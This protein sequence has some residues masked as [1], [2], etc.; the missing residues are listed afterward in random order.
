MRRGE[1]VESRHRVSCAVADAG[2]TL[3]HAAGA[4]G[5]PVFPRSAVKPLQALVLLE[6][7]AAQDFGVSQA[8]LALACASHGGE[9]PHV[10]LV[11]SWLAR[12]GLDQGALECGSH[13]PTHGP[14][15]ERLIAAGRAPEPAHNNCSG[16]HAG[17]LTVARHIGAP[18]AGYIA[19]DH[20][21]Q[22]RVAAALA[23][24]AGIDVLPEPAT[25]GC[26]IPTY[27][28]TLAQ[29]ATA[30][31]RLADPQALVAGRR[32]ACREI[33]GAMSAHPQ[34]VAGSG[35]ACTAIM[36]AAPEVVVKTGAEGVYAAALPALRLGLALKVEDGG[37]RA[38]PVA[39][40]ALLEALGALPAPA[41]GRL[42]ELARPVLRNHARKVVG[43]IE[44]APG[45]P[46]FGSQP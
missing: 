22:R 14:S 16:K 10:E 34:L 3:R 17:F 40:I 45:W 42:A 29:L 31:A 35:R 33:C 18:L 6:S 36:T 46:G 15:A 32:A 26:G 19:A 20:P 39:L 25:D 27:P 37:G 8:E 1:R 2:G 24:M 13:P 11:R 4:S 7:G 30:M 44:P 41:R 43:R 28:M 9:P 21:V 23:E 12:L 5:I 38:A